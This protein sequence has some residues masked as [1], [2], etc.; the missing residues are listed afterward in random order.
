MST[1]VVGPLVIKMSSAESFSAYDVDN[2]RTSWMSEM[3]DYIITN[4]SFGMD[5]G[6]R[7]GDGQTHLTWFNVGLGFSFI[8]FDALVS[9][10]FGL[11]VGSSLLTAAV[12]CTV[13]LA[14]VA[15]V[16]QKVFEADSIWAVAGITRKCRFYDVIRVYFPAII[17]QTWRCVDRGCLL[18]FDM[19]Y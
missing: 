13:Q 14:V 12:R 5:H 7:P 6:P 3:K 11:G 19:M 8:I 2:E 16:L 4:S 9:T 18:P 15:L 17:S 10:V 1:Q